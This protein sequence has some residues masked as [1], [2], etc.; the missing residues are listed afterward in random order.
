MTARQ[1]AWAL[2]RRGRGIVAA[3]RAAVVD[4]SRALQLPSRL[5]DSVGH[6]IRGMPGHF[7]VT[8]ACCRLTS[9]MSE[10]ASTSS[11]A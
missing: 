6:T 4:A 5:L 3:V 10:R 11:S 8:T 1:E 9:T 7:G 2:T